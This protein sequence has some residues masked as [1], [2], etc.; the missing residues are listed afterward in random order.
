MVQ[1]N[2]TSKSSDIKTKKLPNKNIVKLLKKIYTTPE[3]EGSF[4]E[5]H[6]LKSILKKTYKKNVSLDI[7]KEWLST[8]RSYTYHKRVS[9]KFPTNPIIAGKI[10]GQWES[11][12]M[13]LPDLAE[14]NDGYK[15]AL[16]AVDVV[17]RFAWVEPLKTK[18]G[19][20]TTQ[21]M[22]NIF[23]RSSP[24]KP[25]ALH[26][27]GGTEF[28]NKHFKK[29]MASKKIIHFLTSTDSRQKAAL[30]ERFNRT[31]KEKIYKFL[32]NNPH[33]SR[34]INVLQDLVTSYNN[35]VHSAHQLKPSE[36]NHDMEGQALWNLYKRYW[37][38]EKDFER[39][40]GQRKPHKK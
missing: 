14:F 36:V 30:A 24:R 37:T 10:D 29:L 8:Q 28:F 9:Y 19:D 33:N 39:V 26:T 2:P 1:K 6:K 34:Y 40:G 31:L 12:L 4:S 3:H 15:I 25:E 32:D 20:A 16:V 35:T 21:A 5:P 13:F 27:D 23:K 7:I 22:M 17:S 38:D 11:D 18:H